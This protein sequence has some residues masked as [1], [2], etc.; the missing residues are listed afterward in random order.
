V[1]E[2]LNRATGRRYQ[3]EGKAAGYVHARHESYGVPACL[4]V[5]DR[6]TRAWLTHPK[7]SKFLRPET[8]FNAT[9]FDAYVNEAST[10][11]TVRD[12]DRLPTMAEVLKGTH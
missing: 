1:V 12:D 5:V 10:P 4:E 6:K 2:H 3:A 8:L 11:E 7:W 9:K